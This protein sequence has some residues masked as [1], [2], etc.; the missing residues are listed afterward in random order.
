MVKKRGF[1]G[2]EWAK[3]KGLC[4]YSWK[5]RVHLIERN[6]KD[7]VVLEAGCGLGW[8]V[9]HF[10]RLA[11]EIHGID[12]SEEDVREAKDKYDASNLLFAVGDV[13][14]I[15]FGNHAFDIV[16]SP[17]VIEHL[18]SPERF[19]DEAH[20]VLK[21][22]GILILWVPNIYSIEGFVTKIMPS[23]LTMQVLKI[24][25]QNDKVSHHRC[26]FRANSVRKLD[27]LCR[28][29]F[30]RIYLERFDDMGYWGN[31]RIMTYLWFLRHRLSNNE[32]LNWIHPS[33]HVEYEKLL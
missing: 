5:R 18:E 31:F 7:K 6:L 10:S 19:I 27:R 13:E 32:L 17:W 21:P 25:A 2:F 24:L 15:S 11:K 26:Y 14:Q 30:E 22:G 12:I 23:S 8:K 9:N 16:Y 33:F 3:E 29:K 4:V 20:R 28:G 1:N